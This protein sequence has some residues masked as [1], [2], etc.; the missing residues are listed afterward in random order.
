[1]SGAVTETT[2]ESIRRATECA[3]WL[4]DNGAHICA[5]MASRGRPV[6]VLESAPPDGLVQ[7]AM[8]ARRTTHGRTV[9]ACVALR[10]GVLVRW[11][12]EARK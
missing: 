4:S 7:P 3:R 5:V 9:T 12:T 6:V 10:D 2:L 8:Q 1:M 11:F